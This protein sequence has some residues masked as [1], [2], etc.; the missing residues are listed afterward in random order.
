MSPTAILAAIAGL[1]AA[2]VVLANVWR[3]RFSHGPAEAILRVADGP[4]RR[5][6]A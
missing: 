3:R 4:S 5:R 6:L 1:Y 2:L